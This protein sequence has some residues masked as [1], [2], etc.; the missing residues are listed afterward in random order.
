[1]Q[2]LGEM[3][4]FLAG[5]FCFDASFSGLPECLKTGRSTFLEKDEREAPGALAL[6][7]SVVPVMLERVM[8]PFA[9]GGNFSQANIRRGVIESGRYC[10]KI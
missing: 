4:S 2:C 7:S 3:P 6:G 10:E 8:V 9:E 5:P 1:M